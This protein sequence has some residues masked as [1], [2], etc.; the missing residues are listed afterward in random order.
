[1]LHSQ[2]TLG[3]PN[4]RANNGI[5]GSFLEHSQFHRSRHCAGRVD[6]GPP[7]Q[8]VGRDLRVVDKEDGAPQ[9]LQ[10]NQIPCESHSAHCRLIA[11]A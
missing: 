3:C 7:F 8:E 4:Q 9:D 10:S 1:M 5:R 2:P 6:H 11:V